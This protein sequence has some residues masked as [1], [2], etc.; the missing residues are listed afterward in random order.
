MYNIQVIYGD[1]YPHIFFSFV[2]VT[3]DH[4]TLLVG[5]ISSFYAPQEI[6]AI[7]IKEVDDVAIEEMWK[8]KAQAGLSDADQKLL[9]KY[10]GPHLTKGLKGAYFTISYQGNL[11]MWYLHGA[12]GTEL[13]LV[14]NIA[15][16]PE[17]TSGNIY[18]L[19]K[20]QYN[21]AASQHQ[22][23]NQKIRFAVKSIDIPTLKKVVKHKTLKQY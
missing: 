21:L 19:Y 6:R 4:M 17:D 7:D 2:C 1:L 18:N 15:P 10:N 22:N 23:A 9:D 20:A 14:D 3:K 12:R 5:K 13:D 16:L 8:V 11:V